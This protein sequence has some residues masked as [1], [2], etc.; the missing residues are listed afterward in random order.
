MTNSIDL[1]Q[2]NANL[3]EM[4]ERVEPPLDAAARNFDITLAD[5]SR[6]SL[7]TF[8]A[9][10]VQHLYREGLTPPRE[11]TRDAALAEA[12]AILPHTRPE[13]PDEAYARILLDVR[14]DPA[15]V[16]NHLIDDITAVIKAQQRRR[17]MSAVITRHLGACTL[18]A[19][20]AL[21]RAMRTDHPE[22]FPPALAEL[23]DHELAHYLLTLLRSTEILPEID[24]SLIDWLG[25]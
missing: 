25:G 16:L 15:N 9:Q 20:V 2:L 22:W 8:L 21:V 7:H 5:T 23:D 4:A 6:A 24:N 11:I 13:H 14:S 17:Q 12:L 1:E 18:E 19:R 10:L 3:T